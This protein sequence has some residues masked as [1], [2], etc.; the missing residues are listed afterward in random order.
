MKYLLAFVLLLASQI[1][2]AQDT[3]RVIHADSTHH[4]IDSTHD[5]KLRIINMNPFFTLHVDS[6][7]QYTFEINKPT[8][9]YYWYLKNAP[10]GLKLDK[11]TGTLYFKADKSFF[12]SGK[13]KYDVEYKVQMGVQNLQDPTDKVDTFCTVL[14]YSTEITPSRVK[15][16]INNV[17]MLEE[18]DSVKFKVQCDEG[19]FPTEHITL[20][21]NIPISDYKTVRKC[22]DQ[23]EWVVPY[24]FIKDNDTARQRQ[25]NLYFIGADK[26]YNRDTAVV[27][28]I[29]KPGIDYPKQNELHRKIQEEVSAYINDL[30][31][32]FY[33]V[34]SSV[35]KNKS[36]R[37]TFDVTGSTTALAGTVLATTGSTETAKDIGKILPSVGLTLVPVKEAV[38]PSKVQEQNTAAQIR[39]VI[40]RLEYLQSENA[41]T[42]PRDVN[43]I[44]KTKKLQDELKQTRFQLIDLPLVEFD[45]NVSKEDADKYFK[46]PKVNKKYKLKVN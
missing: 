5:D 2:T 20:L 3:T 34:S 45:P 37:T 15:P 32:T 14:F 11:A 22:D 35:K 43:V 8:E 33:V 39:T 12:R 10:V 42:G 23:F 6:I 7:L 16:T 4:H 17:M 25:L 21:T 18:G 41:L 44:A 46:D 24:D 19:S 30:K 28:L 29:V 38:A 27:T 40:K 26:F 9:R 36:T 1:I 31:L 13:L